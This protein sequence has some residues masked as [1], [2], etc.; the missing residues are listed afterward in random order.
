MK[1]PLETKVQQVG[2][3]VLS[4][5]QHWAPNDRKPQSHQDTIKPYIN[6]IRHVDTKNTYLSTHPQRG[7]VESY[8]PTY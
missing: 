6:A 3:D 5:E 8:H 1:G 4:K 7:E 2:Q